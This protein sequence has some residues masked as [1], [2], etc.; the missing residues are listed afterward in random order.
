MNSI[1]NNFNNN[2]QNKS[3]KVNDMN[4]FDTLQKARQDLV[5]EIQAIM[6]YDNHIHTSMD[7]VARATWENIKNE[8]LTHVGELLA[9]LNYLEP[10]QMQFVQD[11]INEFNKRLNN[12]NM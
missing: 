7:N 6:E 8:E 5:G 9:L 3:I 2:Q 4:N 1:F 11:G 10:Q 12:N